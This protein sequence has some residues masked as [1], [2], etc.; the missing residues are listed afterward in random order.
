[1]NTWG[2]IYDCLAGKCEH[3]KTH[4]GIAC[5]KAHEFVTMF[6]KHPLDLLHSNELISKLFCVPTTMMWYPDDPEPVDIA[7]IVNTLKLRN[8]VLPNSEFEVL[9]S[10]QAYLDVYYVMLELIVCSLG[11]KVCNHELM[12]V[13]DIA[14]CDANRAREIWMKSPPKGHES[15]AEIPQKFIDVETPMTVVS[16]LFSMVAR[17][18][19]PRALEIISYLLSEYSCCKPMNNKETPSVDAYI[20]SMCSRSMFVSL[21]TTMGSYFVP[22]SE[23]SP[24]RHRA[25]FGNNPQACKCGVSWLRLRHDTGGET[26]TCVCQALGGQCAS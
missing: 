4:D 22:T 12:T 6:M 26:K 20:T 3:D 13:G 14:P 19:Q 17:G 11:L 21:V 15:S 2:K 10:D 7:H 5:E 8:Q 18:L 9:I 16:I 24:E 1:M 23:L 25:A